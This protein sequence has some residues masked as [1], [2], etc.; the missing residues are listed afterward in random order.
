MRSSPTRVLP[1]PQGP[2]IVRPQMKAFI[3]AAGH[4][5]RL[6]PLTDTIPKCLVPIRGIPML[7]VWLDMC[8][9]SGVTEVFLNLHAHAEV[10]RAA[11]TGRQ[12]GLRVVLSEERELLGSAGTLL[13]NRAWIAESQEFWVF[14]ADVLTN[15]NLGRMLAFHRS[16]PQAATIG[17]YRVPDPKRCGV[18][19]FDDNY[20][21]REFVEKPETP[22]SNWA[23]AGV[24]VGTPELLDAIPQHTPSDIGFHVLP[25]LVG[26]M[27]AYPIS[28][29]LIDIGTMQNY[30]RAQSDWPGLS[31]TKENILR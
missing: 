28:E 18:A 31:S 10:V 9:A 12:T 27:H 29:Y 7:H 5:T 15:L 20:L 25:R 3:L 19:V 4:G 1:K 2:L 11:I 16:R 22:A 14:Y 24:M 6:K 30:E 26:R 21:I 8:E 23:F 13:A 17:V